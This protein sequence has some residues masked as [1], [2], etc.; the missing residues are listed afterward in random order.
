MQDPADRGP[1]PYGAPDTVKTVNMALVDGDGDVSALEGRFGP[2]P[3]PG[4]TA[5]DND[6]PAASA[7]G[8]GTIRR[9]PTAVEADRYGGLLH[10]PGYN[11]NT[12]DALPTATQDAVSAYTRSP[13]LN[14]FARL[15]PLNE[16]TVQAELDRIRDESRSHPGWQVYEIGGGRWPDLAR[17]EEAAE[18]GGLSPEQERIVRRVLDSP[19]PEAALENFYERSGSAGQ[20]AESLALRDEPAHFPDSSEV[21]AL[22]R[23]LDRATG[24]PFPEG[25]E[26]VHGMYEHLHLLGEGSTDPLALAGTTH[27]EQGHLSVSLGTVPSAAGGSPIDL[28]RL[29]VPEGTRGLWVGDRSEHPGEREVILA[30]GTRYRITSVEP[31]G[32]GYLFHAEILPPAHDADG[33]AAAPAWTGEVLDRIDRALDADDTAAALAGIRGAAERFTAD[34]A[35]AVRDADGPGRTAAV[36]RLEQLRDA[37][38]RLA[39]RASKIAGTAPEAVAATVALAA[40]LAAAAESVAARGAADAAAAR[41]AVPEPSEVDPEDPDRITDAARERDTALTRVSDAD[42]AREDAERA[43]RI[44]YEAADTAARTAR[45]TG[46]GAGARVGEARA[47][48][49]TADTRRRAAITA[50]EDAADRHESLTRAVNVAANIAIGIALGDVTASHG[51]AAATAAALDRARSIADLTFPGSAARMKLNMRMNAMGLSAPVGPGDPV[52]LAVTDIA[53]EVR[54]PDGDGTGMSD[55]ELDSLDRRLGLT[56]TDD[57]EPDLAEATG[58]ATG[59]PPSD[60]TERGPGA[61]PAADSPLDTFHSALNT[62]TPPV[63]SGPVTGEESSGPGAG[64]SP[65]PV[66]ARSAPEPN[67]DGETTEAAPAETGVSRGQETPPDPLPAETGESRGDVVHAP[68]P[69][70]AEALANTREVPPS[71]NSDGEENAPPPPASPE[72][73][74]NDGTESESSVQSVGTDDTEHAPPPPPP[75]QRT[76]SPPP[77][78]DTDTTTDPVDTTDPVNTVDTTG[79]EQPPPPPQTS[80]Q[81]TDTTTDDA[82]TEHAPPPP[83]Q[84]TTDADTGNTTTDNGRN[85]QQQE[86]PT[87]HYPGSVT[88]DRT[89][90]P[91]DLGYLLTSSLVNSSMVHA[92]HLRSFVNDT[93]TNNAGG[94]DAAARDAVR[95]QVDKQA[96]KQMGVFFRPEGFSTTVTGADGSTWQADVRLNASRD[97]FHHAPTQPDRGSSSTELKLVDEAGEANPVTGGGNHGGSK[98]VGLGF[99]VSPLLLGTVSGTDLG[100]RFTINFS[101]GTRQRQTGETTASTHD[102]YTSYEIKGKPEVYASDLT[103]SFDLTPVP[104]PGDGPARDN[105]STDGD[106]PADSDTPANDNTQTEGNTP[107]VQGVNARAE[108]PNGV[109]LVLPGKVVANAGPDAIRLRDPFATEGHQRG[110]DNPR[111]AGPHTDKGHTVWVG[112]IRVSDGS[113]DKPFTDWVTDHLWSPERDRGWWKSMVDKVTPEFVDK[114]RQQKLDAFKDQ[115]GE[116]FSEKSIRNNLAKMTSAPAVFHVTDPSGRPR[117][118]SIRSVPTS[119]DAKPHTIQPAKYIKGNKSEREVGTSL[120]HHDFFG[121]TLGAGISADAGTPGGTHKIRVDAISVEGGMRGRAT[122]ES[123]R[124]LSGSSNRINY[125]KTE[126]S[127]YDVQRNY[128]VHFDAES[129]VYRFQGDTVEIL[130]VQEARILNGDEPSDKVPVPPTPVRTEGNTTAPPTVNTPETAPDTTRNERT[131]NEEGENGQNT[132]GQTEGERPAGEAPPGEPRSQNEGSEAPRPPRPNLAEDQPVTFHGSVP[133]DFT[134]PDG[135]QYRDV[136]GQQRSIYQ[137]IAHEVLTGLAAKRPGLVLPDLA[138][139]PKN[140][141]RRPGHEATGPFTGSPREHR[142]FRRDHEAAVFN[143]HRVMDAISASGFKSGT[144]DL[145]LHGQPIHLVETGRFDPGAL[146]KPGKDTLRPPFVTVRLT[147]DFSSLRHVGETTRGT[148]GEYSGAAERNTG[149]SSQTRKTVRVATGGYARRIDSVDAAGNPSDGGVFSVS[150]R[151]NTT[152]ERGRGLGVKTQSDEIIQYAENSSVWN[153]T[154]QFSAKLYEN[155]DLGMV[156]GGD[157]TLTDRGHDLLDAPIQALATMDTAKAVPGGEGGDRNGAAPQATQIQPIP[158]D[159]VKE[160]IDGHT[161]PTPDSVRKRRDVTGTVKRWFGGGQDRQPPAEQTPTPTPGQQET[162]GDV[163]TPPTTD[164]TDNNDGTND[165]TATTATTATTD[166]STNNQQNTETAPPPDTTQN[167][168][169]Q[170]DTTGN[171]PGQQ[172]TGSQT[173]DVRTPPTTDTNNDSTNNPQNTE[174]ATP[175]D[176]TQNTTGQQDTTGNTPDVRTPEQRRAELIRDLGPTIEHVN[177]RFSTGDDNR[178]GS[179]LDASYENFSSVPRWERGEGVQRTPG[180]F[181]FERK[182]RHFLV[183]G[184]GSRQFYENVFSPENLAGNPALQSSGGMRTRT[185]MSG[186]LLSPHHV[187]ATTA[188]QFDIDSVDRFEQSDGAI[189]WKDKNTLEVFTKEG[190]RTDVTLL[191]TGGGRFN[192]NPIQPAVQPADSIAPAPNSASAPLI[193]LGPS[194]GKSLFDRYTN[195]RPTSKYSETVEFHPKIQ[196]SYSFS[197]SGRVTQAMEFVKNWSIGPTIPRAAR[198]RGWQAHVR[199]LVTGLVHIRDAHQSGLVQ[200]RVEETGD[201]LVRVPQPEPDR[202]ASVRPRPG[203]EDSGK[204]VRP[205]NPND[206]LQSLADD[207]ASQGWQLTKDSRETVL[208]TLNSHTGLNPNTGTPVSVKVS[209]ID[210]SIG[211]L[212]APTTAPLSLDATVNL[213]LDRDSTEVKYLGGKTE[214]RQ[215]QGWEDGDRFQQ[216]QENSV[217][218]GAQGS[219]LSPLRQS[220]GDQPGG[221]DPTSRPYLMGV[222]GDAST[223]NTHG[224][225]GINRNTDKRSIGLT[226]ETP[227]ARV[228]SDTRLTIDLHISDKQGVANSL[229]GETPGSGG[230]RDFTGTGDSGRVEALYPTPYLDLSEPSNTTGDTNTTRPTE[231]TRTTSNGQR[232]ENRPPPENPSNDHHASLSDMMRNWSQTRDP[233]SR[234]DFGDA[235]VLP[236]AVENN[237]R[238]VRDL[239]HVVV[240]KSLGWNPPANSVRDGH[241][242]PEAVRQAA[243]Y[244]AN[245]LGLNS[246]NNAI[247]QSLNAIALK[248]LFPEANT[249][250]GTELMEMGRTTWGVRA[251]PRPESARIIDYNPSVR[252]TDSSESSKTFAPFHNE[253]S[254]TTMGID[255][256]PSGRTGTGPPTTATHYGSANNTG[257]STSGGDTVRKSNPKDPPHSDRVRTGPAYLVEIDTTWAIGVKSELRGPWYKRSARYVG[258]KTADAGRAVRG[259]FSDRNTP[260][261]GPSRPARWQR[262]ETSAKVTTWISHGDAVRLGIITP[263]N[264]TRIAPLTERFANLQKSLGDAEKAYLEARLPM[265][266]AAS[267]RIASPDDPVVQQRYTDLETTYEDRLEAFNTALRNW[268]TALRELHDGLNDPSSLPRPRTASAPPLDT[269]QEEPP[270][271]PPPQRDAPDPAADPAAIELPGRNNRVP[272]GNSRTPE[273]GNGQRET[274][275]NM[276]DTLSSDFN[277]RQSEAPAPPSTEERGR[278][279][280]EGVVPEP[281][282]DGLL[283]SYETPRTTEEWDRYFEDLAT[284]RPLH[285]AGE[286]GLSPHDADLSDGPAGQRSSPRPRTDGLFGPSTTLIT[287]REQDRPDQSP[288]QRPQPAPSEE[289]GLAEAAENA[290]FTFGGQRLPPTGTEHHHDTHPQPDQD[291]FSETSS[292]NSDTLRDMQLRLEQLRSSSPLPSEGGEPSPPATDPT[293]DHGEQRSPHQPETHPEHSTDPRPDQETYSDAPSLN[294]D[295]LREMRLRLERLMS[296]SPLPSEGDEPSPPGTDPTGEDRDRDGRPHGGTSAQPPPPISEETSG[297]EPQPLPRGEG[298]EDSHPRNDRDVP[299]QEGPP[300]SPEQPSPLSDPTFDLAAFFNQELNGPASGPRPVTPSPERKAPADGSADS[301]SPLPGSGESRPTPETE[302]PAPEEKAPGS[303]DGHGTPPHQEQTQSDPVQETADPETAPGESGPDPSHEQPEG[304]DA[305]EENKAAPADED[306]HEDKDGPGGNGGDRSNS[307]GD[308]SG[309][310]NEGQDNDQPPADTT[311]APTDRG[312]EQPHGQ[313]EQ[314]PAP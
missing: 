146:V 28:M 309:R 216:G 145:T 49:E 286:D 139:D 103:M 243:E 161:A 25:F 170:Q 81:N 236:A 195:T 48:A 196:M 314:H 33:A 92:E 101:G 192:P 148:G 160:M 155:D 91:Y 163:R 179:L 138:R 157:R 64:P 190:K 57:A 296:T 19:Y 37:A 297:A 73:T 302:E 173:G 291:A 27:V 83:P 14:R 36:G 260:A 58:P 207:L 268:E 310:D 311:P 90:D 66:P 250:A 220:G 18:R 285:S 115:V 177:T 119:Y 234:G 200:D 63:R 159:Q 194:A 26:A 280:E 20:I 71:G 300:L 205:A 39:D 1:S 113:S 46:H 122:E 263:D 240:A 127:A 24:R 130:T 111:P 62:Q 298:D 210:H 123:M 231:N 245:K 106:T 199:D 258:N 182:L 247:D 144:D 156:L 53:G 185:E 292:L 9:L 186:G 211:N 154:V 290:V 232:T 30:R 226:M 279:N 77:Q 264:A 98:F 151:L 51:D 307:E 191:A 40:D 55:A 283:G 304:E 242:T 4:R 241:Y 32:R 75:P 174:T 269:I 176:T 277:I 208:H 289:D 253:S 221:T 305:S 86:I 114:R 214:Y 299:Q 76:P 272:E 259:V 61:H 110:R 54:D 125:G 3:T 78:H 261:T 162:T 68:V 17:L 158:V 99:Q 13:W 84:H 312:G 265:D 217:S 267:D 87:L 287:T 306:K 168:T 218:A 275:R 121:G 184:Q 117:L 140:F 105:E 166:T 59:T 198:Y 22:L 124:L 107:A 164:T 129:T 135:N 69:T 141:A 143:T 238:D 252:L 171:T 251:V 270:L 95:E 165:T 15:R 219:L 284:D 50:A 152:K 222:Y 288:D 262:G 42:T 301:R 93:L 45:T 133:R 204:M 16:A 47:A 12:F 118:V 72:T 128:Y 100:P 70:G 41:D 150:G 136:D 239:A 227:Y 237:G 197:A 294:S 10:D 5:T 88:P 223:T 230:R 188:T 108:S 38:E 120:R 303:E 212:N 80:Q 225:G 21:L 201:G 255:A 131:G 257:S 112:D 2:A 281:G 67:T 31:W 249:K 172:N 96:R 82:N 248:A 273:G 44:A 224:D 89:G 180:R 132:E 7:S 293:G 246:R 65:R 181:G 308:R 215:R 79:T 97:G 256:R 169:G 189:V 104:D 85:T 202:P 266:G 206:A 295:D 313:G 228:S 276:L 282:I 153:S 142:P 254:T 278:L 60:R 244:G 43:S 134:W 56:G 109:L 149:D 167:T 34:L 213:R 233:A 178:V 235:V 271:P 52:V 203:F 23:R 74:E 102:G 147:A 229:T 35:S 8:S 183:R 187:R 94:V 137:Q 175:P 116:T 193:Q 29:T 126:S 11:P 209:P 6:G 274:E